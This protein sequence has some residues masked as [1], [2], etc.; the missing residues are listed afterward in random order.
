M[1]V[2]QWLDRF[3]LD[4]VGL[5][6]RRLNVLVAVH[7]SEEPLRVLKSVTI[8]VGPS[9]RFINPTYFSLKVVP[10]R[11]EIQPVR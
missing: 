9:R 8:K 2:L 5:S 7:L 4:A 11:F 10:Q 1:A 6:S 3:S